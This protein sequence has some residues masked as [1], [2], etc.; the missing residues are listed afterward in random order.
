MSKTTYKVHPLRSNIE[1][2]NFKWSLNRYCSPRDLYLFTFG[3]NTGLRISD[4]LPLKVKHVKNESHIPIIQKKNKKLRLVKIDH[5]AHITNEYIKHMSS[6]DYLFPSRKGNS[7]ITTTQAYRTLVK[8][9][10][11]VDIDYVG[12]HTLR[13]TF[14]YHH[15]KRNKDVATL[16]EIFS[17]SSPEV[18]KIYIG[19][20]QEDMDDSINFIL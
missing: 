2:D 9:G 7:F 13:K 3:I 20:A 15:Y 1:I 18:T 5:F 11:M 12:T 6:D 19:I 8:A 14:G 16:Q 4:I 10:N 17:H